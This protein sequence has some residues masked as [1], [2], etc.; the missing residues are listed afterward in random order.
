MA[1]A[2]AWLLA[3]GCGGSSPNG[4]ST[5]SPIQSGNQVLRITFQGPC[6]PVDNALRLFPIVFSRVALRQDGTD[7]VATASGATAGD[8]ELRFRA[9]GSMPGGAVSVTGSIKGIARHMP[10]IVPN[11]P[12]WESFVNFGGDGRSTLTGVGFPVTTITPTAGMDGIGGG[13]IT[14]GNSSGMTCSGSAFSWSMAPS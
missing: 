12:S 8:V 2:A 3:A 13:T 11:Q 4:P 9:T 5:P 1:T 14:L 6:P 10:E 7:W